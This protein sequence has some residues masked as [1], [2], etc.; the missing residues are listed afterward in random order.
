MEEFERKANRYNL[1]FLLFANLFL[2]LVWI[3]N[4]S[5]VFIIDEHL[6]NSCVWSS[7]VLAIATVLFAYYVGTDKSWVK[8]VVVTSIVF[9]IS[10]MSTA[11]TY[12][13]TLLY[14]MPLIYSCMYQK[15]R[16]VYYT[17][18]LTVISIFIT[19]MTGYYV[20]LCD[21]NMVLLTSMPM[22][23]Y[24]N[25]TD[26]SYHFGPV[27][28][29]PWV[30]LPLY[31]GVPRCILI[32][33]LVPLL[34]HVADTAA[35]M[36]HKEEKLQ[37]LSETDQMTKLFNRNKYL[38]MSKHHYPNC[39]K[40]GVMFFD[41]NGL[42]ATNDELG[43]EIGDKLIISVSSAIRDIVPSN[44]NAYRIGGDEF[45]I[46]LEGTSEE[47]LE[48]QM[49]K[50]LRKWEQSM[51]AKNRESLVRISAA[52]GHA[53]GNGYDFEEVLKRA[54]ENMYEAKQKRKKE[55]EV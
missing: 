19:I 18:S 31:Y 6:L 54:D 38:S 29:N 25:F 1:R 4:V 9:E 50:M 36:A 39:I 42:K 14:I 26:M 7:L 53:T 33:V 52:E 41:V 28:P 17:Y 20:G 37:T 3:L 16:V 15:R 11:L 13:A 44:G 5:G 40:V 10:I 32:T 30:T 2:I 27:N 48:T 51:E 35:K 55:M 49:I 12:H 21:A 22:K 45:V 34:L 47:L 8:Y 24:V 43:H 46:I 23:E